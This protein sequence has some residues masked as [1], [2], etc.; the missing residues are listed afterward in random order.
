MPPCK[1]AIA[2]HQGLIRALLRNIVAEVA[3]AEVAGEACSALELLELLKN[4]VADLVIVDIDLLKKRGIKTITQIKH[5][6]PKIKI[7]AVHKSRPHV[8]HALPRCVD[9][10]FSIEHARGELHAAIE[11]I[12]RG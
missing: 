2:Y 9:G 11:T 8:S 7:L 5:L 1:I 12:Q 4:S 3:G 6:F 10:C